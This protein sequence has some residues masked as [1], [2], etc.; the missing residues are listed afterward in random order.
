MDLTR[1]A[2]A[3]ALLAALTATATELIPNGSFEQDTA[4]GAA[5]PSRGKF[6]V[7]SGV[8]RTTTQE[9]SD[10]K[11]SLQF[12][13]LG[14]DAETWH[15]TAPFALT[16]GRLYQMSY[17]AKQ[18]NTPASAYLCLKYQL[19]RPGNPGEYVVFPWPDTAPG[20]PT[21]A[22]RTYGPGSPGQIYL[23][24]PK[25]APRQC[26][27]FNDGK[28]SLDPKTFGDRPVDATLS[29]CVKGIGNVWLDA[30]S[31]RELPPE[32]GISQANKEEAKRLLLAAQGQTPRRPPTTAPAL[33]DVPSPD[34]PADF[35]LDT[36]RYPAAATN[37][38]V[39]RGCFLRDGKPVFLLGGEC[40]SPFMFKL[41]GFDFQ[42]YSSFLSPTEAKRG[43]DGKLQLA[44]GSYPFLGTT[45]AESLRSGVMF[46]LDILQGYKQWQ[47]KELRAKAP[48]LFVDHEGFFCW[49]PEHPVG[50]KI[51]YNVW[52]PAIRVARRYPIFAYELFNEVSYC[53]YSPYNLALFQER[54][55]NKYGSIDRA[56]QAWDTKFLSFYEVPAPG[57]PD[58][59]PE[60]SGPAHPQLRTD[61]RLFT[62]ERFGAI[63]AESAAWARKQVPNSIMTIQSYCQLQFDFQND[64]RCSPRLKA[65][66]ED[67]YACEQ[68]GAI[69][70]QWRGAV[71]EREI[72]FSLA[73]LAII[74][75]LVGICPDK[76]VID[77]ECPITEGLKGASPSTTVLDL[78][79]DWKFNPAVPG[80]DCGRADWPD[81]SWATIKSPGM[82]GTQGFPNCTAGWYR[83]SFD[84]KE[85][86]GPLFLCGRELADRATVYL[87]GRP[88][89]KTTDWNEPFS[90]DLTGQLSPDGHNVLAIHIE[91]SYF[92]NGFFWGGVRGPISISSIPH[93]HVPMS[94]D[95]LASA[96]WQ[97]AL[98]GLDGLCLSYLY[99]T[100]V[101]PES[102]ALLNPQ[103]YAPEAIAS[104]PSIKTSINN[105]AEF[106]LPKPRPKADVAL[107]YSLDSFRA[108]R[109]PDNEPLSCHRNLDF[110]RAYAA[111]LCS[112]RSVELIDDQRLQNL[113]PHDYRVVA[114][115]L[116]ERAEPATLAKLEA[117][118][119]AGG[120]VLVD[121]VSLSQNNFDGS[122]LDCSAFLG[123]KRGAPLPT[124]DDVRF[125]WGYSCRTVV[126]ESHPGSG[127]PLLPLD[128]RPLAHGADGAVAATRRQLGTGQVVTL[129]AELSA[130]DNARV[131]DRLLSDTGLEPL[132]KTTP[133]APYLET[134]L[135]EHGGRQLWCLHNW[136][137]EVSVRV[138]PGHVPTGG[139]FRVRD[140]RSGAAL[141]SLWTADA[142][143]Q[144]VE[145]R[146]RNL[147]P[148]ILLVEPADL[149]PLP[150]PV[151]PANQLAS[152]ERLHAP[153]WRNNAYKNDRVLW[154]GVS[155]QTPATRPSAAA[156]LRGM[157]FALDVMA[158]KDFAARVKVLRGRETVPAEL[159][160]YKLV[161][162]SKP[163]GRIEPGPARQLLD[164]VRA[165][166]ALLLLGTHSHD[167]HSYNSSWQ[168]AL[169]G[170][171]GITLQD[172]ALADPAHCRRGEP[173]FLTTSKVTPHPA[174]AG[175]GRFHSCGSA[176][177]ASTAPETTTLIAAENSGAILMARELGAGR[178]AVMGDSEWL[179]PDGLAEG[180]NAMLLTSLV[181]WLTHSTPVPAAAGAAT[182]EN[183]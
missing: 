174:T 164:Y 34:L 72:L 92:Q 40:L 148:A 50:Q 107:V 169:P 124:P 97:R 85:A 152:L 57:S 130:A 135:F 100:E 150:L 141:G 145:L 177:V 16:P 51:R 28:F 71:D 95:H 84:L 183:W 10:G 46:W 67:I 108:Y 21:E 182:L 133:A 5:F 47:S 42:V 56:N 45:I 82:W 12:T 137:E 4:V 119:K 35:E 118:A 86:Q 168:G 140:A 88:I 149:P 29:I 89:L 17:R 44:F 87:N 14:P 79:G 73:P 25:G 63:C 129:A 74:D 69:F 48:E 146:L 61:W 106:F 114:L 62:E 7:G 39:G 157:G 27:G 9:A 181:A 6:A 111:L 8:C 26:R 147:S 110:L 54:C 138:V 52:A 160:A 22:W 64:A 134:H 80:E 96:L 3:T 66:A 175:V 165:G 159:A 49:R 98:H 83:K 104:L 32:D 101:A 166:G 171:L 122:P 163:L 123:A 15:A 173:R 170:L 116:A 156:V 128:A 77:G 78:A 105:V 59:P 19:D 155:Q 91:N 41:F 117:F 102:S 1:L 158:D 167:I 38:K 33:L 43:P 60:L 65:A 178:V 109:G 144:G 103:R 120:T 37:V 99:N 132:L 36:E 75:Y 23:P 131:F 125:G 172:G 93:E 113:Q 58:C 136:G 55:R 143:R 2:A 127:R 162:L 68:G 18:D 81:S 112:G 90:L 24:V 126:P 20:A 142:L 176:P 115:F 121:A 161:I 139:P 179:S 153:L 94:P 154:Y 31:L 30:V 180:D 70:A 53:D 151:P 11:R 76:P 13:G